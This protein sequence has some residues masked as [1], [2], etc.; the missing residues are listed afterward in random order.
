MDGPPRRKASEMP[1]ICSLTRKS[2]VQTVTIE[3]K[4]ADNKVYLTECLIT[5][6]C[7]PTHKQRCRTKFRIRSKHNQQLIN[8]SFQPGYKVCKLIKVPVLHQSF[9]LCINRILDSSFVTVR[10]K[11]SRLYQFYP[12]IPNIQYQMGVAVP[13][14]KLNRSDRADFCSDCHVASELTILPTTLAVEPGSLHTIGVIAHLQVRCMFN[15]L[16]GDMRQRS[17][18]DVAQLR[19]IYGS[20]RT[21]TSCLPRRLRPRPLL[22]KASCAACTKRVRNETFPSEVGQCNVL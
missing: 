6:N 14:I 5:H 16:G 1:A 22:R 9:T 10:F 8:T 17:T 3:E 11:Y 12:L 18:T 7:R 19:L 13:H 4:Q 2:R 20:Q 15:S 21:P